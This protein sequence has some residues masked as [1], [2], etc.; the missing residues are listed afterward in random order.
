MPDLQPADHGPAFDHAILFGAL[1]RRRASQG[2]GGR[3]HQ[4]A[5]AL[6]A[7]RHSFSP[8]FPSR[9]PAPIYGKL[10]AADHAEKFLI[11]LV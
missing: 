11:L 5:A 9:S 1:S 10:L 2:L 4:T 7:T 8:V 3:P 6:T